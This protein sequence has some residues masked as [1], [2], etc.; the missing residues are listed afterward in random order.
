ME[1][2]SFERN[3]FGK[4]LRTML[5]VDFRRMFTMPFLYIM[6]GVCLIM[7]V[8]ILVMTTMMDGTVSVN[9]QTGVETV[10][11][12]FDNVWQII[13]SVSD[14]ASANSE[15]AAMDMSITAMCNINMLYFV[16]AV[17]VCVFVSDDFRSG[18]AKNLFTVRAKKT[19]YVLSK[20]L[21]CFVGGAMMI[22]AFFMGAM[23]GGAISGLSFSMVGF[24]VGE[25]MMCILSKV[26]LVVVFVSI[27]L[28]MSVIAKQKTWLSI[29]LSMMV[30]MFLFMMIPMLTPLNATIMNV[31]ICVVGG[32]LFGTGM[33][34]ISQR[35][36]KKKDIL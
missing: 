10:V 24:S 13:G 16:I 5:S 7:P 8:L 1:K 30:G 6:V 28:M 33:G 29:L 18:Y 9:P 2:V 21:V 35:I 23:L 36:L 20:M 17:L 27:Y 34:A 14:D 25:L 22:L 19:D 11:E 31:L 26:I 3:T 4:R 32:V 15:P 12:G